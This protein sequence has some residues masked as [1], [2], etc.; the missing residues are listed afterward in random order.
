[1]PELWILEFRT[2]ERKNGKWSEWSPIANDVHTAYSY[3][4]ADKVVQYDKYEKRAVRYDRAEYKV[5]S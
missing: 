1:M 2:R 5:N 4:P 3:Y